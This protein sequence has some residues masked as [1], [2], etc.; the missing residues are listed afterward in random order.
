MICFS[1]LRNKLFTLL[2]LILTVSSGMAQPTLRDSLILEYLFESTEDTIA[3]DSSGSGLHGIIRGGA[4]R[5]EGFRGMGLE[6][7]DTD[8]H[9][10]AGNMEDL[11][12][13]EKF[14]IATWLNPYSRGSD[15]TRIEVIEKSHQYWMNI[16]RE[17]GQ[18]R[19]GGFFVAR[20][21]TTN[22]KWYYMDGDTPIPLNGWTHVAFTY[23]DTVMTSYLNGRPVNSYRVDLDV[24]KT[25]YDFSVGSKQPMY[26]KVDEQPAAWFHGLM[27]QFML[28]RRTLDQ[29]EIISLMNLDNPT[30]LQPEPPT[31][32]TANS[33]VAGRVL[34]T[35]TDQA[36]NEDEYWIYTSLNGTNWSFAG[37][38][39][40][41]STRY[42][43][44]GGDPGSTLH[45][46]V[47]AAGLSGRSGFSGSVQATFQA[48]PE[49]VPESVYGFEGNVDDLM[50]SRHGLHNDKMTFGEGI[51][52]L[53]LA[54]NGED[55]YASIPYNL[56]DDF[57][58]SMW[59]KTDQPGFSGNKTDWF[60]G[61]GLLDGN[62][63]GFCG[64]FGL[65]L[66]D[67]NFAFGTGG[68]NSHKTI[69]ATST[70]TN[71][72][73][74]HLAATFDTG[75][76]SMKLYVDGELES[77][78]EDGK[79]AP[80]N[81]AGRLAIGSLQR[82][83]NYFNGMIDEMK[84]YGQVLSAGDIVRIIE[85]DT[86]TVN[87]DLVEGIFLPGMAVYPNPA[88]DLLYVRSARHLEIVLFDIRGQVTRRQALSPGDPVR[89]SGLQPGIYILQATDEKG[90][91]GNVRF[92]KQ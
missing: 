58:V 25:D 45:F 47:C 23:D 39:G 1:P 35:W 28:F 8:V 87:P 36:E 62:V 4:V 12:D 6:F 44:T 52:G 83:E 64:E 80:K 66:F 43:Y 68:F 48:E 56:V 10:L 89:L 92:I 57:S 77:S 18:L 84:L 15:A 42:S 33:D 13:L 46:R 91:S 19:V 34:L 26:E 59:V 90:R 17:T 16:R 40:K 55:S 88:T 69:M 27:D 79:T 53:A 20:G 41:D 32:L 14:T 29:E 85:A 22:E 7:N 54:C 5:A 71:G 21:E 38:T 31:G 61:S 63:G 81:A 82:D 3:V 24:H 65:S 2:L 30:A 11:L 76:G 70:V 51:S 73:W 9:I 75:T 72:E 50:G 60:K 74:H 49:P 86:A 37:W 78:A 67:V